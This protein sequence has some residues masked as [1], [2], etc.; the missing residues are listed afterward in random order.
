LGFYREITDMERTTVPKFVSLEETNQSMTEN[1]I[2]S[3]IFRLEDGIMTNEDYIFHISKYSSLRDMV[4]QSLIYD[5]CYSF[6]NTS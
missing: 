5:M 6:E 3:L 2:S 1:D 4:E